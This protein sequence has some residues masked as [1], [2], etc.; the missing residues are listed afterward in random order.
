MA[1]LRPHR[2]LL[3]IGTSYLELAKCYYEP[4]QILERIGKVA[5][6]LLLSK[7]SRI[8]PVF[9]CSILKPFHHSSTSTCYSVALPP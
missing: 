7:G 5:Y 9:H 2:Q 3:A 6:R 4:F 8:H 1:K